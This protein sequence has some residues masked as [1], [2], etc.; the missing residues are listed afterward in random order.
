[1]RSLTRNSSS[2]DLVRR[3]QSSAEC[4]G[5]KATFLLGFA[6]TLVVLEGSC[7]PPA[8]EAPF[9]TASDSGANALCD[10]LGFMLDVDDE[11]VA[12]NLE[13]GC[14]SGCLKLKV[15]IEEDEEYKARGVEAPDLSDDEDVVRSDVVGLVG[16]EIS[17]TDGMALRLLAAI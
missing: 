1:M 2:P 14:R 13:D 16:G 15:G 9:N 11:A 8:I 12:T 10:G 5:D 3:A 6:G 7:K 17:W 4:P